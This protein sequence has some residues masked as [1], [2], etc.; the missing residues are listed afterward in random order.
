MQAFG[1]EKTEIRNYEKYLGRAKKTG[2]RTHLKTSLAIAFFF[3]VMFGYYAYAFYVGSY[4]ITGEVF[5]PKFNRDYTNGDILSCFFGIVFGVFSLGMATPNIKA[6]TEGKVAGKI[7]YDIIDRRPKILLDDINAEPV[8]H[9]T[10]KIE[11]K[12]VTFRYPT[13]P[14]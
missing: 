9:I 3:A 5:N 14:E 11:F 1:Q 2:V 8:G 13:R 4:F 6:I 10:G 12:N 7:A